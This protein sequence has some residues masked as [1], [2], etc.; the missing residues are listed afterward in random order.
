MRRPIAV[1]TNDILIDKIEKLEDKFNADIL[2]IDGPIS[3][4]L[5]AEVMEEI[6]N[7][8]IMGG[9]RDSLCVMLTTNGGDANSA[10]RLVN[11]LRHH[12]SMVNFI[13]PDHAY[14]AGTILCMS[15]DKIYMNYNSV[16]GPIDPQVQN[17]EGR[18]V[19]ALGY[20][21]KIEGLLAEAKNGTIS[22]AEFLI[23]KDFDLAELSLY[24]Q[25][26]DLTVDLLTNWLK[27]YKFK[28]WKKHK[29]TNKRVTEKEKDLRATEIATELGNYKRWKA[30]GRPLN[31]EAITSLKLKIDDFG[32]DEETESMILSFY[33][34]AT[35]FM[36]TNGIM[37]MTFS[38]GGRL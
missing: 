32:D 16:L 20:L 2:Y 17:K 21:E 35:D 12:Y 9:L 10:E 30:H 14:S 6:D 11:V 27:K 18:Y 24:E 36:R 34:M 31:I 25:A 19:P 22:Q 38:R 26:R 29:S 8:K 1:T 3:G 37:A 5:H 7:L 13:I 33:K 15:G 4:G 23:L 28:D